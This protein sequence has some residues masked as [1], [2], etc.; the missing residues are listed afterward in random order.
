ML[1]GVVRYTCALLGTLLF[2]GLVLAQSEVGTTSLNGTIKD[3]SGATV[4][5]AQ[6]SARNSATGF[7]RQ[8]VSTGTG[9]YNL[10]G[11]PV[12]AYE[13]TVEMQGFK[14][15]RVPD[16]NL[17]VGA[18]A[19]LNIDLQIGTSTAEINVVS[20]APLVETSRTV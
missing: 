15:T 9:F 6:V 14:T 2:T 10:T 5:N 18:A 8:T 19:T 1:A 11:L 3:P 7:V 4:A 20:E 17:S 13:V 12:G 16:V